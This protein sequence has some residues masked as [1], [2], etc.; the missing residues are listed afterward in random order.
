MV[1][2][3]FFYSVLLRDSASQE[4]VIRVKAYFFLDIRIASDWFNNNGIEWS[5]A[6]VILISNYL[7]KAK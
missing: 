3:L 2:E 1:F 6:K 4:F 7:M 5:Y